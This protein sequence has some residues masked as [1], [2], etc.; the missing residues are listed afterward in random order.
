MKKISWIAII[1]LIII[2]AGAGAWVGLCFR[3]IEIPVNR[4]FMVHEEIGPAEAGGIGNL[5][6]LRNPF[7]DGQIRRDH[8]GIRS[9]FR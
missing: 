4:F 6:Q 3:Q 5:P 2:L 8:Q 7:A 1:V 9:R